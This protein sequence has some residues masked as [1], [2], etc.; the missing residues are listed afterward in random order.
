MTVGR[1]TSILH[2][3][4][5]VGVSSD[6]GDWLSNNSHRPFLD[7]LLETLSRDS[8]VVLLANVIDEGVRAGAC[9]GRSAESSNVGGEDIS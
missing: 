8:E 1:N 9:G 6:S 3:V 4:S 2:I 7:I 5:M